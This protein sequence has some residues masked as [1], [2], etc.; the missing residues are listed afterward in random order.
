VGEGGGG[1]KGKRTGEMTNK[2]RPLMFVLG[3]EGGGKGEK[4]PLNRQTFK[5][6]G[7]VQGGQGKRGKKRKK[8]GVFQLKFFTHA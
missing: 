6:R 3:G 7:D 5:K 8:K 1:G 2:T 4:R